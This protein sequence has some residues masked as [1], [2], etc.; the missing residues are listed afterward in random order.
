M[1]FQQRA[2]LNRTLAWTRYVRA[3]VTES[4]TGDQGRGTVM[5]IGKGRASCGNWK[6]VIRP[7]FSV[8]PKETVLFC[9]QNAVFGTR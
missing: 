5:T 4:I 7:Q 6:R 2:G 8:Q 3:G 9:S 1:D